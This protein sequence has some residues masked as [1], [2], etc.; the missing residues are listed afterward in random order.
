MI[1]QCKGYIKAY[2]CLYLPIQRIWTTYIWLCSLQTAKKVLLYNTSQRVLLYI[3]SQGEPSYMAS[4]PS[5]NFNFVLQIFVK[6]CQNDIQVVLKYF[7][8]FVML[9]I[10]SVLIVSGQGH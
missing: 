9:H 10:P 3:T 5:I 2:V 6:K 7:T 1:G 8:P 4:I